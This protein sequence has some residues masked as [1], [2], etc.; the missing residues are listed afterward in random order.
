MKNKSFYSFSYTTSNNLLLSL[1]VQSVPLQLLA[2]GNGSVDR[3]SAYH[4]N[5]LRLLL[6]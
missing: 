3:E 4:A 6:R 1:I 5:E 2:D